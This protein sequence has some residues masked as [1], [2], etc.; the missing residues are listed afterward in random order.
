L[1]STSDVFWYGASYSPLIFSEADWLTDLQSMQ[2]ASMNLIRLGDVH[3]SWDLIEPREGHYEFDQLGRFYRLAAELGIHILISTGAASPPLWLAERYPDLP[4]LSN[5]GERYPLGASYHWACIHHPAYRAAAE[6]YLQALLDF[7]AAQPNHFGWQIS[8]EIGFPFLPARGEADLSLYCYCPY[9]VEKFRGWVKAKYHTLDQVTKAWAWGTTCLVYNDWEQIFAPEALPSGWAGVTRWMDWRLFW[10]QAFAEF[11]GW[12]HQIIRRRDPHHPT[13]VNTFNFKGYDRFGVFTGLDQWKIAAEVDHIGYDLYPGSGNKLATR[14]EHISIFLDHGR[15]VSQSAG[16]DFWLHEVESGPIGG[17][18]M[19]PDYNTRPADVS[20]YL[21]EAVGHNAK[22][23]LFMPW[24]EW[25]YQPLHWGALVDLDGKPTGRLAAAAQFGA[26]LSKHGRELKQAKPPKAQV[27]ILESKANAIFLRGVG[28]EEALFEAQRGAYR[29][30]WEAGFEVDFITPDQI[31]QYRWQGYRVIVL[32][33]MGLLDEFT[34]QHLA[35][36]VRQ[37]GLLVGFAR[38]ATVNERGWFHHQVPA[39]PLR[40]VFGLVDV[41]P[42]RL[43][44]HRIHLNGEWY[45][46]YR[47]R[48]LLALHSSTSVLAEF[49]DHFPAVTLASFGQGYGLYF[50]TQADADYLKS[51]PSLLGTVL[52]QVLPQLNIVPP[53]RIEYEGKQSRRVD[54]HLLE[55]GNKKWLLISNYLKKAVDL[56]IQ[57]D[58]SGWGRDLRKISKIFPAHQLLEWEVTAQQ[59]LTL[60]FHLEAEEVTVIEIELA[61]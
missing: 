39:P 2:R 9:C 23:I 54:P 31:A 44:Q 3:G 5:R 12:Q 17:W 4:I 55:L 8:N 47:N 58:M 20:N 11:A 6:K 35:E 60:R 45:S 42:D 24:R 14:P 38:C 49:D 15:S 27:A 41:Q 56:T 21:I 57:T 59:V 40:D 51:A 22:L 48:D 30:F 50:A 33:L 25:D 1:T 10:Q 52:N 16:R 7:T 19:G 29:S 13:S 61:A 46:G 32:P 18:V 53:I 43:D 26:F 37:G 34:A 36:F 28:E